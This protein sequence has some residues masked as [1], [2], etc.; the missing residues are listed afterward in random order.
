MEHSSSAPRSLRVIPDRLAIR[1]QLFSE[2]PLGCGSSRVKTSFSRGHVA[3]FQ[4]KNSILSTQKGLRTAQNLLR[5][6]RK[7][8]HPRG[9]FLFFPCIACSIREFVRRTL[10]PLPI[11]R[12]PPFSVTS[13]FGRGLGWGLPV[14]RPPASISPPPDIATEHFRT[15]LNT[16]SDLRPVAVAFL[17]PSATS[18]SS[19][20]AW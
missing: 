13:P 5:N 3:L 10:C 15:L 14:L 4:L 16:F 12:G 7:S 19:R 11:E 1:C 20:S 6:A 18:Y 2:F 8:S 9:L 17:V